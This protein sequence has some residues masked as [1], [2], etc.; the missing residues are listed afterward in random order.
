MAGSSLALGLAVFTKL[1]VVFLLA[2]I[3]G[4]ST[5]WLCD[6]PRNL[7]LT[8]IGGIFIAVGYAF[9]QLKSAT[10]SVDTSA[11]LQYVP[12]SGAATL[13]LSLGMALTMPYLMLKK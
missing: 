7:M 3:I 6:K 12:S 8:V 11:L 4:A 5:Y 13:V 10:V 9:S 2:W 1:D